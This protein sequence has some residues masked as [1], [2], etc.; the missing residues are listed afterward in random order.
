MQESC[1]RTEDKIKKLQDD[2]KTLLK[3]G[4][5]K[6]AVTLLSHKKKLEN[7]WEKLYG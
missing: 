1:K 7:L 3:A 2:I 4:S 6:N 5:K